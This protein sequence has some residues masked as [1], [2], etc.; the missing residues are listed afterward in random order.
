MVEAAFVSYFDL[1][2]NAGTAGATH[3]V[4]IEFANWGAA[5]AVMQNEFAQKVDEASRRVLGRT[6]SEVMDDS[7]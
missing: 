1:V 6:W 3:M 2:K 7:R 5:G 4:I